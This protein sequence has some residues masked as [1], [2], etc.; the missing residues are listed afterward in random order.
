MAFIDPKNSEVDIIQAAG[1]AIRKSDTKTV[2][3]IVIPVFVDRD[4]DTET[5]LD[6]SAFKPVWNV[7]RALRSH[8]E[9]LAAELDE[10]R[11]GLGREGGIPRIPRKIH[12]DLPDHVGSDFA[13]A[14]NVRLVEQS[15]AS[16]E[17]W[18]GLLERY[19]ARTGDGRVPVSH[20]E[21]GRKLG[22]WVVA[23]R[24]NRVKGL[25]SGEQENRLAALP[26]W[27]WNTYDAMW[28]EGFEALKRY[29]E[30]HGDAR[31]PHDCILDG[32][33]LGQWVVARRSQYKQGAL[34]SHLA[35]QLE[36]LPG[37]IWNTY[38][39]AW[40]NGY[41]ALKRYAEIN[42]TVRIAQKL[43]FDGVNLSSW[44]VAQRS[45]H[46]S[47]RLD[48]DKAA[49]LE[50]LPGWTWDPFTDDW[51]QG[52]YQLEKYV[53][54][55]GDALVELSWVSDGFKLGKWVARQRAFY[56]TGRLSAERESRLTSL[57]G[58]VWDAREAS[59]D[60]GF[61]RLQKHVA[62]GGSA[63]PTFTTEVDGYPL[64]NWV[65]QQRHDYRKGE[66]TRARIELLNQVPGWSWDPDK[67]SWDAGFARLQ[68]YVV[69]HGNSA[70]PTA[71]VDADGFRLGRWVHS[72]RHEHLKR[73]SDPDRDRQLEEL[74]GW[75]WQ[76]KSD[77]W[78]VGYTH[79]QQY[80]KLHGHLDIPKKLVI[81]GYKLGG[82]VETQRSK[83][84]SGKLKPDRQQ[85]L[86]ELPG[87][88]WE[89]PR[90]DPFEVGVSHLQ[91]YFEAHGDCTV[92]S[93]YVVNGYRL[94]SWVLNQRSRYRRGEISAELKNRLESFP[95]WVWHTRDYAWEVAFKRAK[96]YAAEHGDARI[97]ISYVTPDGFR[98]GQWVN[99]QRHSH[100]RNKIRSDRRQKLE[101]LPRWVWRAV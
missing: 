39:A 44:V 42:G 17:F 60:R 33:S 59:W 2:G 62:A 11:R 86:E 23:Q 65:I 29:V 15:S 38:E 14:F 4:E 98:L 1:R 49:A 69:E 100:S 5:A 50:Q 54:R 32:F 46:R 57:P 80:L 20:L 77:A 28:E 85:R 64:G 83:R 56:K 52:F 40:Q 10:L 81:D 19:V 6:S 91:R 93:D 43:K 45:R 61:Q 30:T 48:P 41:T 24:H 18:F 55:K 73:K 3:T 7:L 25:L 90:E 26:G 71:F 58:W 96:Q 76:P 67:E 74:P 92:P 101:S 36:E 47:G 78:E 75:M 27:I 13:E 84:R 70:V 87:W 51:E 94:G 12:V 8:D 95:G 9:E 88:L 63:C 53:A 68:Q 22:S 82:W 72:R 99:G 35:A 66:L 37:W 34:P 89:V 79:L 16:W 97:P 21:R 31:V